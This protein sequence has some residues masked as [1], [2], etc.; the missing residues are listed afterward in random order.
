[1]HLP[2][3]GHGDMLG[4][5]S[6]AAPDLLPRKELAL[7]L[8]HTG[9]SSCERRNAAGMLSQT[10][11]P[12]PKERRGAT[13]TLHTCKGERPVYTLTWKVLSVVRES[14][15]RWSRAMNW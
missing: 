8:P 11:K 4:K 1:M 13:Y 9:R 10:A 3:S 6:A 12:R 15:L 14:S 5:D 2:V 7:P